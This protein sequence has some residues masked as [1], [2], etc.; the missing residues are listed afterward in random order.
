MKVSNALCDTTNVLGAIKNPK[1]FGFSPT[2]SADQN[3]AALQTTVAG[4]GL[5]TI[6]TPG[7]YELNNT[8]LLDSNTKLMCAPGVVFKK[9]APYC[10]VLLNRGALTKEYNENITIDGLEI[11]VNGHEAMPTL[12]YG[13]RS[14]LGFFYVKDLSIKNI[15]C[16]DGGPRQFLVYIVTWER[17]H[18]ENVRLAGD[19]DGI[20]LNNGHDAVINNLDL[21]TYDDGLSLCGTDYPSV[22][23]EVGDVYNVRYTSTLVY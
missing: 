22:V 3:V 15:T 2:A 8:I 4:G 9:V 16:L 17:L 23:V 12:V 1:T 11:S 7:V 10:N 6:D 5:I 18:I 19:K 20:K 21:T 14:Q 13:L